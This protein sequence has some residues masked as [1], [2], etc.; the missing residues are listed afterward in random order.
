MF[1]CML[2]VRKISYIHL[3]SIHYSTQQSQTTRND[4]EKTI[5][6]APPCLQRMLLHLQ[7]YDYT[8]VYKPRCE[9]VLADC[10][11]QFPPGKNICL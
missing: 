3:W 7:K 11:S 8:I 6:A 9:M 2:W 5:H 1:I 10:L 4:S